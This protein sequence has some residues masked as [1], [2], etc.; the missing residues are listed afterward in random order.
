M[1]RVTEFYVPVVISN[2][3]GPHRTQRR[4]SLMTNSFGPDSINILACIGISIDKQ[5]N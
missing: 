1:A 5:T 3:H 4:L 2:A